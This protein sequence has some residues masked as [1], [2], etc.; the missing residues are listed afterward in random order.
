MI[1]CL[2]GRRLPAVL[3]S[4]VALSFGAIDSAHATQ[5][6]ANAH[7]AA[8]SARSIAVHIEGARNVGPI[9][10]AET[11]AIAS[12]G[13][14][15][16]ASASAVNIENGGLTID[17]ADAQA[18][19]ADNEAMAAAQVNKFHI[20]VLMWTGNIVIEADYIGASVS[21]SSNPGGKTA[22]DSK[23]KMQNLTVN[24]QSVAITGQANQE[25]KL[26]NDVRLI[27][28]EQV[29]DSVRGSADV[30][31]TA[32]HFWA[33]DI[34]GHVGQ[35]NAGIT[36]NGPPTP[37]EEHTC[38]KVTGGGWITGAPSGVKGTFGVSGGVRRGAFWG[39]LTYIDHG[40]GMKVE[41]TAV[42]GFQV[43]PSDSTA[44]II[45]Y[46]VTINGVSGTATVRVSDRGE[47]G[48]ND[49]FEIAL[50]NG[51]HA[52]GDLGGSRPGG[53]NIQVHKCPP[54]WE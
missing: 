18:V 14:A 43:D 7:T 6:S 13:G 4:L 51:Y 27:I 10:I 8:Y 48:T 37:P 30:Q 25:V 12:A 1:P 38:G 36:V 21:A 35:I 46:A 11:G 45:S 2:S 19:G 39:H 52:A 3:A 15:L 44:R 28:N 31:L 54:G 24:G 26:P 47:P 53:G 34:E 17:T 22:L 5:P 50:S 23:V 29:S 41:S 20:E 16:T 49:T 9:F 33:C 42:T 32:L 40:T